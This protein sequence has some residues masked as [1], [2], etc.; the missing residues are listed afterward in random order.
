LRV[1]GFGER[2]ILSSTWYGSGE[3]YIKKNVYEA[4]R[5]KE[6]KERFSSSSFSL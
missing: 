5:E 6:V 4:K 1:A 3:F 2:L